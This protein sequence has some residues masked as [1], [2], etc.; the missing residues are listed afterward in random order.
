MI[1]AYLFISLTNLPTF[2]YESK[3]SGEITDILFNPSLVS[4]LSIFSSFISFL[5]Y[6]F[7]IIISPKYSAKQ[8]AA[9]FPDGKFIA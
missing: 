6:L 5:P 1:L 8:V 3:Y 7:K 2:Y 9:S 4:T